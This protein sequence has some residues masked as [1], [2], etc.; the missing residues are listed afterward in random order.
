MMRR[1]SKHIVHILT[2]Q[3]NKRN[4]KLAGNNDD[5]PVITSRLELV[6]NCTVAFSHVINIEKI[7]RINTFAA[8]TEVLVS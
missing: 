1:E 3:I 2:H 4:C 8:C 6:V 7:S 5:C